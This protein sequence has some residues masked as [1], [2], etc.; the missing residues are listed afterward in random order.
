MLLLS[1]CSILDEMLILL[2]Y[3]AP[4]IDIILDDLD[5]GPNHSSTVMS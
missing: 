4:V 2:A 5:E 1:L 3:Q